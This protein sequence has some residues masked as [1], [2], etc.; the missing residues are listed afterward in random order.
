MR[1]DLTPPAPQFSTALREVLET[2]ASGQDEAGQPCKQYQTTSLNSR[3]T[4]LRVLAILDE[5]GLEPEAVEIHAEGEG[6]SEPSAKNPVTY[7]RAERTS[8]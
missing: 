7:I 3:D 1:V 8:A 2:I 4:K 5:L 6:G